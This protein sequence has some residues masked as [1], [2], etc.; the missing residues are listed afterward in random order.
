M[1]EELGNAP[2]DVL[3][4]LHARRS[5]D[6]LQ[7]FVVDHPS[8]PSVLVLTGTDVYPDISSDPVAQ[9]SMELA[10]RL[11]VL[12]PLA[13]DR[14]PPHI[15][16]KTRVIYQSV[17][18]PDHQTARSNSTFEVC[19]I[20]HL[21]DV[22]DPFRTALAV[23]LLPDNSTLHVTHAGEALTPDMKKKAQA[24]NDT[25]PRYD[26]L[27]LVPRSRAM[28]ILERSRLL[29]LSSLL[30][31]GA[32]V[33]SEAL[34]AS[35]PIIS[36]NIPGSVGILGADYPG[37][38]PVEDTEALAQLLGQAEMDESFYQTLQ[39]HCESRKHLIDPARELRCWSELLAELG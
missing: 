10:T 39:N 8:N 9:Q 18:S 3:I 23:K 2:V 21:R 24:E 28:N 6:G 20:G 17:P 4:A 33:I 12:Q 38:F 32:N 36:S 16:D 7:Q 37:Y 35:V 25:N 11:V 15:Q 31:G 29:V 34:A 14:L 27:G 1:P 22:K 5:A 19:V 26:W 13:M 30:E